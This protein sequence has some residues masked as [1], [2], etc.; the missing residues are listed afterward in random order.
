MQ[1][2]ENQRIHAFQ[3]KAER[4][5]IDRRHSSCANY[6]ALFDVAKEGDFLF[7]LPAQVTFRA[8]QQYI[9]LN[10]DTEQFLDGVLRGLGFQFLGGGD[11]R[12]QRE[13]D[14]D[15]IFA[16]QLLAHLTDGLKKR[17]RFYV[18]HRAADLDNRHVRAIRRNL[19]HSV[20]DFV[21]HVGN[22]LDGLAQ[23]VAAPF[24]EDNLLVD[25]PRREVVVARERR[26]SKSLIMAQ[27]EVGFSAVVGD[28]NLAVLEGRH[29]SRIDV[30]IGVEL[31]HVHAQA[32]LFQQAAD[33]GCCQAF[34]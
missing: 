26:M 11:P 34:T 32:A 31:H 1:I 6:R 3:R 30:E 27:V 24:F 14:K 20:L 10:A 2:L 5:F 4:H 19:A 9:C 29:G 17:Q 23:V 8:A 7:H 33:G 15:S 18:T 13:M 22:Y 16:A 12:H 28:K 21:G 25:A